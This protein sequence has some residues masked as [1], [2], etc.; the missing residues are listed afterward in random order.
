MMGLEAAM[1]YYLDIGMDN[2]ETRILYLIN[3]II[4]GLTDLGYRIDSCTDHEKRSGIIVFS[5]PDADQLVDEL[6]SENVIVAVRNGKIRVSPHFY[7]NDE[8]VHR[9]LEI[10]KR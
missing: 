4:D 2:I 8:D 5:V 10:L 1:D 6:R 3:S 7:N 9:F